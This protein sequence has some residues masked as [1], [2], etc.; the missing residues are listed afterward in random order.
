MP[1]TQT[2]SEN[3][4]LFKAKAGHCREGGRQPCTLVTLL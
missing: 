4:L 1:N 2:V 3:L